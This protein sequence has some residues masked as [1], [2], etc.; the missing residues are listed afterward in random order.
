MARFAR[1]LGHE[2]DLGFHGWALAFGV[3]GFI[4][5]VTG[6]HMSLTW[7][8]AKYFPYDHIIFGETSFGFGVLLL[9]FALSGLGFFLFAALNFFTH[10]GLII[11]TTTT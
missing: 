10:I 2:N 5:T 11:H 8:M 9:S 4:L 3:P 1:T 7:S 6:M